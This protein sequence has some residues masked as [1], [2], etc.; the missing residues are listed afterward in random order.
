[1]KL[2]IYI[3][4]LLLLCIFPLDAQQERSESYIRI[5]APVSLAG[6][7][8]EIE[9][10]TNYSFIYDA[11]V[12]NLSEKV[13]KPLSG[14]SVF[15]ILNLLF[16]NTEIVY[17]VMNDQIILNKKEAIIQMQQKLDGKVKGIVTDHKGEPIACVNVVEKE[18]ETVRLRIWMAALYWSFPRRLLWFFLISVIV[19]GKLSM[20]GNCH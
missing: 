15:E 7:L 8:D 18:R 1:M 4:I 16:K 11:Q 10:Q 17:T 5:S 9:S 20:R 12:I 3:F 6:A 14:R 19:H 2:Y 13:R